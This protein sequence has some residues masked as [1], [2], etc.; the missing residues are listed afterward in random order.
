[1]SKTA[2][3]SAVC[4][5]LSTL[6]IGLTYYSGSRP[7]LRMSVSDPSVSKEGK[8]NK[9]LKKNKSDSALDGLYKNFSQHSTGSHD[10]PQPIWGWFRR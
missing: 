5:G 10:N 2:W 6:A 8:K 3:V 9:H 1:M 4:A 7:Q